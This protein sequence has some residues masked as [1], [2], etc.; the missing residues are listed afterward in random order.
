MSGN[1]TNDTKKRENIGKRLKNFIMGE[2]SLFATMLLIVV[3]II[4]LVSA[5]F[6]VFRITYNRAMRL[7]SRR[8]AR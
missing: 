4:S 3:I 6:G 8:A 1:D 2:T 5:Y 7:R